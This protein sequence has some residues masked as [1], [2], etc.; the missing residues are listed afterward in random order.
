M[1]AARDSRPVLVTGGAG[2]IGCNLVDRLCREGH[3]VIVYDSLARPGVERNLE[4]LRASHRDKVVVEVADIRDGARL[5]TVASL[6]R[7][8]RL[9]YSH[10]AE[11]TWFEVAFGLARVSSVQPGA[12]Y[13]KLQSCLIRAQLG[14][15]QS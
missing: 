7:S 10:R 2:F 6:P 8:R 4:W 12:A 5:A 15:E 1:S 9:R 3:R 14:G 11:M 13:C